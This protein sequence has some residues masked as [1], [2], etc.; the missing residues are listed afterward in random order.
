V[1]RGLDFPRVD[2]V[3][4]YDTP[5]DAREYIHRVGRTARINHQG[6]SVGA[7]VPLCAVVAVPYCA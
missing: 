3:V 2:W 6:R 5:G 1:A 4:Q 7:A